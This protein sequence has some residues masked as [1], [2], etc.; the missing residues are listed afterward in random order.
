MARARNPYQWL[1]AP[2]AEELFDGPFAELRQR[3]ETEA[4]QEGL[5]PLDQKQWAV[6]RFVLDFYWRE[7]RVPVAVKIGRACGLGVKELYNLFPAG[8]AKTS[9][10]LAG[11][12]LPPELPHQKAL[13][14]WN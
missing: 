6:I 12:E 11:F 4:V 7:H 8:A 13:S 5:A 10:R 2:V 9:L 1:T 14:W 3:I